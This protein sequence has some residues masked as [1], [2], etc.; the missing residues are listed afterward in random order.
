MGE[1]SKL[2]FLSPTLPSLS[3]QG[4][5]MRAGVLLEALSAD[6]DISLVVYD[7]YSKQRFNQDGSCVSRWCVDFTAV[8]GLTTEAAIPFSTRHF[9]VI[10]V[11]KLSTADRFARAHLLVNPTFPVLRVLDLDDYESHTRLQ[12][13]RLALATGDLERARWEES[14]ARRF[15]C[16]ERALLPGFDS[17]YVC[18]QLDRMR[19][20]ASYREARVVVVP[21]AVRLPA[22]ES[23][24]RISRRVTLLFVGTLD[25]YPNEDGIVY[26]SQEVLPILRRVAPVSFQIFVVGARPPRRVR[27]LARS[28]EMKLVGE[29]ASLDPVYNAADLIIVPLRA[30]GGTRIKLLEAFAYGRPVVSTSTGA[31]GLEVRDREHLLLANNPQQ[32]ARA[33]ITLMCD[34]TLASQMAARAYNWVAENHSLDCVRRSLRAHLQV[35]HY[36]AQSSDRFRMPV[37]PARAQLSGLLREGSPLRQ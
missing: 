29:V 3:G 1:K 18:S 12:F 25:Y 15:A 33:C 34:P 37:S 5:A 9:D 32:F 19:L 30:G 31:A 16:L 14:E 17:V 4:S 35:I 13:A 24:P 36:G 27:A 11:F 26:F 22:R 7:A 21:N 2:L 10:H 28:P 8:P 20:S 6:F 23:A